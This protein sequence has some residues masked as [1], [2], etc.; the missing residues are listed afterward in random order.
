M[1]QQG[2]KATLITIYMRHCI[3]FLTYTAKNPSIYFY[4]FIQYSPI[5][6]SNVI[7]KYNVFYAKS[8]ARIMSNQNHIKVV[9]T[10]SS[11][12]CRRHTQHFFA[13]FT[14]INSEEQCTFI[15]TKTQLAC[16]TPMYDSTK[17]NACVLAHN[18]NNILYQD[19]CK[20]S[21]LFHNTEQLVHKFPA[22]FKP[23]TYLPM[24]W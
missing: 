21:I 22:E 16:T 15:F 23:V 9:K 7:S 14:G 12:S 6:W 24:T 10:D 20:M 18:S 13:S 17:A 3:S 1:T 5:N 8:N 4:L 2:A 11:M 19:D